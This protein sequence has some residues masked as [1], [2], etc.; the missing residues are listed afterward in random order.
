MASIRG[1]VPGSGYGNGFVDSLVWGGMAWDVA[2]RPIKVW[3]GQSEDFAV[4]GAVHG[5]S[6]ILTRGASVQNWSDLE[7]YVFDYATRVYE[8][9]CGL[10]FERARSAVEADMVWWKSTLDNNVLGIHEVPFNDQI[11][12]YFNPETP[13]W[14]SLYFGGDGLYTILHELGHGVGLAHP[15]DGG[16]REDATTFPGVEDPFSTGAYGLNQGI[17]TI[18]SYNTGWDEAGYDLIYG[19]QA[20]LGAF[21]IAALQALYGKNLKTGQGSD[22]YTL[23]TWN[24]N[25]DLRGWSCLWDAG[26]QDTITAVW[27]SAG[28]TI[29]LRAA[30][31]RSDDPHAG[32]FISREKGVAG[33]YTIA[34]GVVI[35]NAI[36]GRRADKLQGNSA[37]NVLSGDGGADRLLGHAGNDILRGG[38]GND[39]L[40]GGAGRDIFVFDSTIGKRTNV[41]RIY[42]FNS[43]DDSIRL[44]NNIFTE[45]GSDGSSGRKT[46]KADM[47][48]QASK[49]QDRE[50]RIVYDSKKGVL[51][52]DPDG[53]GAAAQVKI[54][55]LPK[56]LKITSNDFFVI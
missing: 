27:A 30:T 12:G 22:V 8:S 33:G 5:P 24:L 11:W 53:S 34:N 29:D 6:E 48:V 21:D 41:D 38:A 14:G 45:L 46:F 37:A 51:S 31:L 50:D 39:K 54:A 10:K 23:P 25:V 56:N 55:M 26:G 7:K 15:H 44:E 19:N 3:F 36:G 1:S 20:G 43:T 47:F 17:W 35:E 52:Y 2:G 28:V 32:G 4:A 40:Y 42:D 9:V 18:M 49:A 13:S 16:A